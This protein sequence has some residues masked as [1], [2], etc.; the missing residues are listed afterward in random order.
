[1]SAP[2]TGV[3]VLGAPRLVL[4]QGV[5]IEP[6]VVLDCREG[7]IWLE[8]GVEVRAFTRLAGPAHI[9]SR[10]V[11][12]GGRFTAVSIGP[13]CKVHGE[14]EETVV[15]GYSNKAHD[16]FL[17]HAYIGRWVNLGAFTTNSDLKNN[18]GPVRLWTPEGEVDT[19]ELKIGCFLGDHVKTAIGSLFNTG[20]VVGPGSNLF[21]GMPPRFVPPFSWGDAGYYDFEKFIATAELAMARR[22]VPL[23][24]SQR[25][26]LHSA[27]ERARMPRLQVR[28]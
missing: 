13:H 20:T 27:W 24:A 22:N 1:W 12:L 17:G 2:P 14:L 28:P 9:G 10:T 26:L 18:Y 8:D 25:K 4:G 19:Q 15:L 23:S 16:G 11:L 3:A 21:G 6:G 5:T 7:P